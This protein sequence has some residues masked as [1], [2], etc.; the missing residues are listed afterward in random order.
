MEGGTNAGVVAITGRASELL[1]RAASTARR[2]ACIW[3][4]WLSSIALASAWSA[5]SGND[6]RG[7]DKARGLGDAKLARSARRTRMPA[8]TP[9][10]AATRPAT[11]VLSGRPS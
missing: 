3:S 2:M 5:E 9:S 7:S 6:P 1:E 10:M 8:C 11:A 4:A